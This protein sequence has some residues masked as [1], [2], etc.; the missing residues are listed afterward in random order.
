MILTVLCIHFCAISGVGVCIGH[1]TSSYGAAIPRSVL[2]N[3]TRSFIHSAPPVKLLPNFSK[4][5]AYGADNITRYL[6]VLDYAA[7]VSAS[8]CNEAWSAADC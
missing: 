5:M 7:Q 3:C 1:D 4:L 8:L 6:H 2:H